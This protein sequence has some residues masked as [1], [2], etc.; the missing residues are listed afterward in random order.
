[1]PVNLPAGS[2]IRPIQTGAYT[3][4]GRTLQA[5]EFF[6][7]ARYNCLVLL[8]LAILQGLGG[9][10]ILAGAMALPNVGQ[11]LV[12]PVASAVSTFVLSA[13]FVGLYLWSRRSPLPAALVGLVIYSTVAAL[14]LLVF[15]AAGMVCAL[16][17]A[18]VIIALIIW[19]LVRAM[20][21]AARYNRLTKQLKARPP[22]GPPA[23][24][25][26]EG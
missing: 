8:I 21:A 1:M 17:F 16:P 12:S 15:L 14:N 9:G 4:A 6:R 13:V 19:L 23:G 7:Q 2:S 22:I 3:W 20:R 18:A 5:K 24:T 25:V 26:H 10:C 11:Q